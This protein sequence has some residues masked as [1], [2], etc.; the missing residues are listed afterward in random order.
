[1]LAVGDWV[2]AEGKGSLLILRQAQ[3]EQLGR[4]D[5]QLGREDDRLA[6]G[7]DRLVGGLDYRGA[8]LLHPL[9]NAAAGNVDVRLRAQ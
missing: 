3:D 4:E 1:M 8:A 7:D 2:K 6:R 5:E 9:P